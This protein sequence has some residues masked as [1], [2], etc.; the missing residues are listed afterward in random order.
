MGENDQGRS[1]LSR[2]F[3]KCADSR[4][5]SE[6]EAE[7]VANW[8]SSAIDYMAMGSCMVFFLPFVRF[9]RGFFF[10]LFPLLSISLLE[11]MGVVYFPK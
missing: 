11:L 10:C 7:G 2:I 1:E 9:F 8:I 6:A 4:V 3:R 5:S